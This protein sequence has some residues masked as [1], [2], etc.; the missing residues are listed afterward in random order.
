LGRRV[1]IE[2]LRRPGRDRLDNAPEAH[3]GQKDAEAR[4]PIGVV[5]GLGVVDA[6]YDC[7][8]RERHRHGD[9]QATEGDD[10]A[11]A[12]LVS[13]PA[14]RQSDDE[15]GEALRRLDVPGVRVGRGRLRHELVHV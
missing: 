2:R 7:V 6:A 10:A 4:E 14:H 5:V 9:Q 3:G 13:C 8:A 11:L 15:V 1:C 12:A